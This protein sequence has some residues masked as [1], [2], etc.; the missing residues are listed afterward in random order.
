MILFL[1]REIGN[2]ASDSF[3]MRLDKQ[4]N[5]FYTCLLFEVLMYFCTMTKAP[6]FIYTSDWKT[7]L[8][9]VVFWGGEQADTVCEQVCTAIFYYVELYLTHSCECDL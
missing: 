2:G 8:L 4:V 3:F 6:L 5:S 9:T 1:Y 7:L